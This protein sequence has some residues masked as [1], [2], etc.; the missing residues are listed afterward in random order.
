MLQSSAKILTHG[1]VVLNFMAE[2]NIVL[3]VRHSLVPQNYSL[4]LNLAL[5]H[6]APF[7]YTMKDLP[8]NLNIDFV[9]PLSAL[10]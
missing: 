7:L 1:K 5:L 8:L 4:T 9:L 2:L 3:L 6:L 10:L